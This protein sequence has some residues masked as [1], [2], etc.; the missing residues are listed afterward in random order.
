MTARVEHLIGLPFTTF[1]VV[2]LPVALVAGMLVDR[3]AS[4]RSREWLLV[5]CSLAVIAVLCGPA[6]TAIGVVFA[7][8]L[9]AVVRRAPNRTLK[10]LAASVFTAAF[11]ATPVW[12]IADLG[13]AGRQVREF[14]AFA[15]NVAVLRFW[16]W[17]WDARDGGSDRE[18]VS[19]YLLAMLFF[20]TFVN[21]PIEAPRSFAGRWRGPDAADVRAGLARLGLGAAKL[22]VVALALEPG[23]T[24][25][26]EGGP[27]APA[28]R[29]W[30][31]GALLYGWFYLSFAA[32]SDVAIG[33]GRLVGRRVQENF[34]RPWLALDPGDFWRRWHVSLGLWL[35]DYVYIPLGGNRRHRTANVLVVFVVS[36]LWHVWGTLKLLGFGYFPVHAWGGFLLWGLLHALGVV[37][38]GGRG[39]A[40]ASPASRTGARIATTAFA[41]WA[42]VP[43]F[44]PASVSFGQ[45]MYMLGRMV[46]P[47]G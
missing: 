43:F 42:W 5:T 17:A 20:P 22:L 23:W 8:G 37:L 40:A 3:V 25:V 2:A 12:C 46:F 15:T 14:T 47:V 4:E 26:L 34:D 28:W 44:V 16:A 18:P 36:A 6:V 32:W 1:I 33:L 11:V 45:T 31:W 35:R 13:A 24:R 41:A 19:R 29:L 38:L 9:R 39:A 30:W 21:G 10:T 7:L 27:S